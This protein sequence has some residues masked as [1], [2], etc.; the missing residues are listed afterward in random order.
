[1]TTPMPRNEDAHLEAAYE[2]R[3]GETFLQLPG[4]TEDYEHYIDDEDGP[5]LPESMEDF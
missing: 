5:E 4:A 3:V 1:M 2:D